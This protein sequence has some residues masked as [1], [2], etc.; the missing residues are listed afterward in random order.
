MYMKTQKRA[1]SRLALWTLAI[2]MLAPK[3]AATA[4]PVLIDANIRNAIEEQLAFDNAVPENKIDLSVNEGIVS[5]SGEVSNALAKER[6]AQVAETVKGVRSVVNQIDVKPFWNRMDWQIQSDIEEAFIYD[7][8]TDSWEIDAEVDDHIATLTGTVSSWEE[9]RLAE[10][11]A[12]GVKGVKGINNQITV[13]YEDERSDLEISE[14]IERR[15]EWDTRVDAGLIDVNVEDG[16]VT[17]TGTVGSA[18]EKAWTTT[19]AWVAGV[20]EVD[21]S[22]LNAEKW[23]RDEDLRPETTVDKED[24]EIEKAVKDALLYDPRVM[25][26]DVEVECD[27]GYV[28]L[29]GKVDNLKAKRAAAQDARNTVSVYKVKNLLKTQA[30]EGIDDSEIKEA[31]EAAFERDPYI[32]QH[33]IGVAVVNNV[34]HLTGSVDSYYEKARAQPSGKSWRGFSGVTGRRRF[35]GRAGRACLPLPA[36]SVPQRCPSPSAGSISTGSGPSIL[37][38]CSKRARPMPRRRICAPRSTPRRPHRATCWPPLPAGSSPITARLR[39]T[40]L[41]WA[42]PSVCPRPCS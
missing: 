18:S 42:S 21:A 19:N 37:A 31:V 29:R 10:R 20:K 12:K 8:A 14:D 15:F 23:A 30:D 2:A 33:E 25:S 39:F 40:P 26:A 38:A 1:L 13:E 9:K 36:C 7:S 11:V 34:V 6:A 28:T 24:S 5:L 41:R 17:L 32:E 27:T 22:E 35:P 3:P 4:E 16:E